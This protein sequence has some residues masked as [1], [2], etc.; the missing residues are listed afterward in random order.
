VIGQAQQCDGV[1]PVN[2]LTMSSIDN[3]VV[4]RP[5]ATFLACSGRE[6]V[7]RISKHTEMN[8]QNNVFLLPWEKYEYLG[9]DEQIF[10]PLQLNEQL[11]PQLKS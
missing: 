4:Q 2:G 9:R 11:R 8:K 10:S 1:A 3:I 6:Q 7:K 5:A